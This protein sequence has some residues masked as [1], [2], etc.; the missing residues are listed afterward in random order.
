MSKDHCLIS[1]LAVSAFQTRD[2]G[3][4][5]VRSTTSGS[6][7]VTTLSFAA[8]SLLLALNFLRLVLALQFLEVALQLVEALLPVAPVVLD[9]V[10]DVLER[11]RLE[12]AGPPL[13]LAAALDQARAL[14]HLE[15]LGHRGQADVE[16]LGQF[17]DRGLARGEARH[18]RAPR[19]G[20]DRGHETGRALRHQ[21][22]RGVQAPQGARARGPDRAQPRGAVAALPAPGESAQ[23]HRR[24]GR[25]LPAPLGGELRQAGPLPQGTATQEQAAGNSTQGEARWPQNLTS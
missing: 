15:V 25:V 7:F 14:E 18:T 22:A 13:R 3:A 24:L 23:G 1:S 21:P 9:P 6:L 4:S 5:K 8:I 16:G 19:L 12:P 17:H 11:I 2:T 10:G 20:R